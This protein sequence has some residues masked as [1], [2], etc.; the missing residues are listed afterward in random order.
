VHLYSANSQQMRNQ[1]TV[2]KRNV[3][4]LFANVSSEMSR[5]RSAAGRLF[6]VGPFP[7]QCVLV[8]RHRSPDR[9]CE[10]PADFDIVHV[11]P[12]RACRHLS[13]S[14]AILHVIRIPDWQPMQVPN[15]RRDPVVFH[16][17]NN[18]ATSSVLGHLELLQ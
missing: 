12:D 7:V 17:S 3:F 11:G 13:A 5:V 2:S 18:Q 8:R 9:R 16:G 4:S 1:P 6:H 15:N 10:R 14:S